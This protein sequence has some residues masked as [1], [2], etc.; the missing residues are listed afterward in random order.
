MTN[1]VSVGGLVLMLVVAY[2]L[3]S[4]RRA[5][6]F[7]IVAWGLA[8]QFAFALFILKTRP[9]A[10]I[11][12]NISQAI[13]RMLG[14]ADAGA[15]F[16]FGSLATDID[17]F[18][19]VFAF[20]VLPTI[21][22]TSALF[23][24]LYHLG[25]MQ[26]VVLVFATLMSKTMRTSGAE[27]L[28]A[29][30]NVFMGMTEAPLVVK[31]FISRMTQSEMMALM[32]CGM[33]T[34]AGGVMAGYIRMGVSAGHLLTASVMAAP[35]GLVLAKMLNPETE[36]PVT[37]DQIQLDLDQ[38]DVNVIDAV[39]HGAS[40]GMRLALNVAAMLIAFVAL[41]ALVN[42]ILSLV[43]VTLQQILG[44]VFA[45]IAFIIGVPLQDV[46]TVG[47]LL[48]QKII[49][50]E[51]VAYSSLTEILK[52]PGALS[53]RSEVIAT[54]ALAGFANLGSIGI[55]IGGIGGIAPD[56]RQ[57]LARL[58]LRALMAGTMATLMTAS[59]AG[60]LL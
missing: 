32:T 5:I 42:G 30:A 33:A 24:V 39:A 57:D 47:S 6:D 43:G 51:F 29:A 40:D 38:G 46:T 41:I 1:V 18:G 31:P 55:M 52:T 58:G 45:P 60:I 17:T 3:S 19:F 9:G 28:A 11:F 20:Q 26:K 44:I 54:Y 37:R 7:R 56:R 21:I 50:N 27:S 16:V 48:G 10:L 12:D 59:I 35:A 36:S 8:L 2:G 15:A 49:M 25:I 53:P 13:T 23:S 14:F 4:N 34:I 22:F